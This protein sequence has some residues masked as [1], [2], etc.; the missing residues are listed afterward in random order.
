MPINYS[1]AYWNN[2]WA[3]Q[4]NV[5]L[6]GGILGAGLGRRLDP[7]TA[8]HLPKPMF[9][10]GGKVPIAEIWMRRFIRSGIT[11][12]SMNTCVLAE[13]IKEHFGSGAKFGV[14]L[15]YV[16]E[17]TPTGTLGGICK[18]ALGNEAKALAPDRGSCSTVT[19]FG[20][21]TLIVPSGDIVANFGD[22]LIEEVY[23]I[24]RTAGAA[25]TM[26]LTEVS[27]DRK[28][29]FGTVL[30]N[31]PQERE[32]PI[33]V[34][35]RITDFL[36]KDPDSPSCL[37]NASI[38]VIELD[39]L[40]ELDRHRT[41]ARLGVTDPFYDFGKHVFPAMLGRIPYAKLSKEYLLWG[42]RFDGPW[43]DVG[44]KRDY[45]RVNERVLDGTI[46]VPLAY[47]ALPWGYLGSKVDIDFSDVQI[48]PPVVIGNNCIV[49]RGARL[50]PYAVIGDGWIVESMAEITNS[51]LW[52]RYPYFVD[53]K[54]E[55]PAGE[56]RRIDRHEI[57]P[58]VRVHE[59]IIA[60]GSIDKDVIEKTVDVRED[61]HMAIVP[62]DYIPVDQRA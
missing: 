21:S 58:G 43:F 60:G 45:L 22:D 55:I 1:D 40:R 26:V 25:L 6:K 36:E 13:S 12:V 56:R 62:I 8:Y 23:D 61:G 38:Y 54:R 14:D 34:S 47:E 3:T 49:G 16:D 5:N 39:L 30:M 37:S 53:G 44:N 50:G 19:G 52:E 46:N 31:S 51:V 2:C 41:E 33:S 48:Q 57:R 4:R 42:V 9:P 7:L 32:P 29:D 20:G 28:R 27:P 59:S 35:G 15:T 17:E 24:H 18:M 10:L 11:D